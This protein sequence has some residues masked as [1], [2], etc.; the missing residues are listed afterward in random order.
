MSDKEEEKQNRKCPFL[1]CPCIGDEC[2]LHV[3]LQQQ[4][5]GG[6]VVGVCAFPALVMMLANRPQAPP[7]Q[8]N[9]HGLR[10]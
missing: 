1:D 4:M 10:K 3:K 8:V 5:L 6:R 9:L 2:V 7:Q